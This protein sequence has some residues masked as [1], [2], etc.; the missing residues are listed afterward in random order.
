MGGML[1][2]GGGGGGLFGGGGAGNPGDMF[3]GMGLDL[4]LHKTPFVGGFF[5]NPDEQRAQQQMEMARQQT[6]A[7]RPIA[8]EAGMNALMGAE[9]YMQPTSDMLAQMYG[10]GAAIGGAQGPTYA[11]PINPAAYGNLGGGGQAPPQQQGGGGGGGGGGL[12]GGV[13]IVGDMLG[14]GGGGGLLSGVPLIGG[15]F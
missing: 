15:L 9:Q 3:G 6:A 14:G 2:G 13:P 5:Q 8:Q 12:L 7:Y 10:P 4:Q 1:G 11:S